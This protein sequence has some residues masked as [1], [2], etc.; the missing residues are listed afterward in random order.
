MCSRSGSS[1]T[2]RTDSRTQSSQ[3]FAAASSSLISASSTIRPARVSTRNMVPGA[4]RPLRTTRRSPTS[5]TPTSDAKTTRPSSV[6]QKRPGRSPLRSST[7]PTRT[8]SVNDTH[9]G[10]SHGSMRVEWY[11]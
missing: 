1:E 4:T 5:T 10:P 9:A 2:G 8:P 7:D 3:G 6:C 11:S